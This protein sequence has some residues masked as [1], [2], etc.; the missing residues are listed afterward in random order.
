MP[1][2][3][4]QKVN[5]G[6]NVEKRSSALSS[7]V[8]TVKTVFYTGVLAASAY[9]GWN[10]LGLDGITNV[11]AFAGGDLI[12][13]NIT[14][15]AEGKRTKLVDKITSMAKQGIAALAMTQ[16]FQYG[17]QLKEKFVPVERLTKLGYGGIEGIVSYL[18][19]NWQNYAMRGAAIAGP[20]LGSVVAANQAIDYTLKN[21]SVKGVFKYLKDNFVNTYKKIVMP[22]T[23]LILTNTALIPTGLNIAVGAGISFLY[24]VKMAYQ[25]IMEPKKSVQ[26]NYTPQYVP[27]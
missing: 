8:D 22:V 27:A 26:E 11:A 3:L 6:I 7:I 23:G 12:A 21:Y 24:A 16:L 13:G 14:N 20:F 19:K 9:T 25:R 4:E 5:N 15:K 2:D 1:E 18:K 17:W 10:W